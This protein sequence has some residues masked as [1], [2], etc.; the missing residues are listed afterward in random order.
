MISQQVMTDMPVVSPAVP[1]MLA[2]TSRMGCLSA[3]WITSCTKEGEEGYSELKC[4][5]SESSH[6]VP[7][8]QEDVDVNEV[9]PGVLEHE[10]T[11]V[12]GN[13]QGND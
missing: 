7:V 10:E 11:D 5:V 13:L 2:S 12:V 1:P 8:L 6:N 9:V 4:G 3:R